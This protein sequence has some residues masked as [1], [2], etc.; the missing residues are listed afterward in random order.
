MPRTIIKKHS[1]KGTS[2]VREHTRFLTDRGVSHNP[3]ERMIN[4]DEMY[5]SLE[6]QYGSL[7]KKIRKLEDKHWNMRVTGAVEGALP[8]VSMEMVNEQLETAQ[9]ELAK[10]EKKLA[11]LLPFK[12]QTMTIKQYTELIS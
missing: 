3:D 6:V 5:E 9:L 4:I 7:S 10:V 12:G 2:G 8:V 11:V 1:R